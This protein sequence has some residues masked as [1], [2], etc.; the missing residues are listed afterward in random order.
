MTKSK[1]KLVAVTKFEKEMIEAMRV[2]PGLQQKVT[3]MLGAVSHRN[4][5]KHAA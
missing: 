2:T 1:G 4:G 5:K 3:K